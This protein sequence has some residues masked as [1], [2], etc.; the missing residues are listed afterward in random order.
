MKMKTKLMVLVLFTLIASS[1][2]ADFRYV[3]QGLEGS[4]AQRIFD[5]IALGENGP[6]VT[7]E[8]SCSVISGL[9]PVGKV[10]PRFYTCTMPGFAKTGRAGSD[11]NRLYS[12][13]ASQANTP[14]RLGT[15]E[16]SAVSALALPG[17]VAPRY[18]T[19]T[20]SPEALR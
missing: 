6:V 7:G 16:C 9:V 2:F 10:A 11:M 1:A 20:V 3:L 18:F 12:S 15:V 13:L 8:V 14:Q 5:A 17:R 19:C 4:A